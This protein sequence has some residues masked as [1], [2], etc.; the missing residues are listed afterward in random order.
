MQVVRVERKSPILTRSSLA[1]LADVASINLTSGCAHGCVY[2]YT[3]SYRNYP[4]ESVVQLYANTADKLRMELRRKRRLPRVVYFSPSSDLFQP[5]PEVLALAHEVLAILCEAGIGVAFLTKGRIPQEHQ[6]LLTAHAKKVHV[7]I[8]L[9]TLDA[10]MAA[11]L[12][13]YAASP[14]ERLEQMRSLAAAGISTMGRA[15]PIIPG[16]TDGDAVF[17]DLCSALQSVGV[18][19]LAAGILFLRPPIV[20][21]L[22]KNLA[23]ECLRTKILEP[24]KSATSLAIHAEKSSIKALSSETRRAIFGR[25]KT[26][27]QSHGIRTY[28][29][30]CKNPDITDSCCQI[31]GS[32]SHQEISAADL[33]LFR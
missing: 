13:P 7:Q 16:V 18:D 31:A 23:D 2:C 9:T 28:P 17:D 14:Q 26:V 22:K 8:G 20:H 11:V 32:I 1:C 3:R 30:G 27:A 12:E 4:G 6:S 24:F 29:C 21:S 15:D 5:I 19:S 10:K 25:L 33:P